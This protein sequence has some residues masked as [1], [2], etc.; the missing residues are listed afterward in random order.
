MH[1]VTHHMDARQ[2]LAFTHP[3]GPSTRNFEPWERIERS[4]LVGF[5]LRRGY[6]ISI[7]V[8]YEPEPLAAC[9]C[10]MVSLYEEVKPVPVADWTYRE[11]QSLRTYA[12][13]LISGVG[14]GQAWF[15]DTTVSVHAKRKFTNAESQHFYG[16]HPNER[17]V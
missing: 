15:T 17:A 5:G 4:H 2:R 7:V 8:C 16:S 9:W 11:S 13:N 3:V 14:E 10:A 12:L 6:V 1:S